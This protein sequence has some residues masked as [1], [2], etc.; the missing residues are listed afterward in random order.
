VAAVEQGIDSALFRSFE[1]CPGRVVLP[2]GILLV[3]MSRIA[4]GSELL[5]L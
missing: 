1:F 3:L 2:V 5:D 4:C